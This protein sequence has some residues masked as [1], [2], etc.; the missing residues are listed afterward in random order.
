M[1]GIKESDWE[2]KAKGSLEKQVL[3]WWLRKKTVESR[4][5]NS[6]KLRMGDLSR[7]TNAVWKIDSGKESKIQRWMMQLKGNS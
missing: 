4:S 6:E 7:V 5:W 2:A 3:A 1:L